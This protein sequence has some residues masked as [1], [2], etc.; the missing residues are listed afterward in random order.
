MRIRVLADVSAVHLY[1]SGG[2]HKLSA[3][4]HGVARVD[5]QI[6]DDLFDVALIGKDGRKILVKRAL[7]IDVLADDAAQHLLQTLNDAV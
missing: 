2:D 7:Q 6:H 1:R 3:L 4:K 5:H